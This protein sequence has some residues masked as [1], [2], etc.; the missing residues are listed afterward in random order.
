MEVA[1]IKAMAK[2]CLL[3]FCV[4][5]VFHATNNNL[6][7]LIIFFVMSSPFRKKVTATMLVYKEIVVLWQ[8]KNN[9]YSWLIVDLC[10]E[11]DKIPLL[12]KLK[13][14]YK[15]SLPGFSFDTT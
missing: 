12:C 5:A 11:S 3:F 2:F 9:T 13:Q 4:V 8:M 15:Y 14:Q 1:D 6:L 7:H 10:I